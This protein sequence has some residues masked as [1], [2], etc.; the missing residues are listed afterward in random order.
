MKTIKANQTRFP[1]I[2]RAI[3]RHLDREQLEGVARHGADAGWSGFTCTR[4]TCQFYKSHKAEILAMAKQDADDFG[5]TMIE[6]VQ[7]FRCLGNSG[8]PDYTQDEIAEALYSGRGECSDIIR[9]AMAWY[10]LETVAR[11]LNP[12]I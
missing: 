11:E 7:G 2:T 4:E 5:T 10:V 1:R 12:E 9:N 3:L 6:M 8:K